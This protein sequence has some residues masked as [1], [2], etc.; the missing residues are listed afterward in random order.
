MHH[1]DG[2]PPLKEK[3]TTHVLYSH[4]IIKFYATLDCQYIQL[5]QRLI[6]DTDSVALS[7]LVN[8]ENQTALALLQ[9]SEQITSCGC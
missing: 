2:R 5:V 4:I 1:D 8:L 3:T 9:H 7:L 6:N